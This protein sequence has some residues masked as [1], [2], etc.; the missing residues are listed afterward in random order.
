MDRLL[1]VLL[2]YACVVIVT[3]WQE[4][5]PAP[6]PGIS[7]EAARAAMDAASDTFDRAIDAATAARTAVP[8]DAGAASRAV[9]Y[10]TIAGQAVARA[11]EDFSEACA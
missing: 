11:V 9:E 4:P 5:T 3:T 7:C 1:Y 10:A 6:A 8:V 2:V